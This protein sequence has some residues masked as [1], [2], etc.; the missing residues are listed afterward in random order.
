M[1]AFPSV[2][3]RLAEAMSARTVH[4]RYY[5]SEV[6]AQVLQHWA[7]GTDRV[8]AVMPTGGGKTVLFTDIVRGHLGASVAIAHRQELVAQISLTLNNFGV[9]HRLVCPPD[10]RKLIIQ[11]HLREHGVTFHD[12]NAPAAVAGVDT[13]AGII[14][15]PEYATWRQSVTL[16]VNDEAHHV[17]KDNKW[18]KAWSVFPNAKYGLG[19]TATPERPDGQGLGEHASGI[20]EAMVVGPGM[21]EL[22]DDGYLCPYQVWT[23]PFQV[24]YSAV[25]V[26]S[27]GEYVHARLVA[28]ED[29]DK[30][31]VG[32]I[33]ETYCARIPGK[34]AICFVSS[35]KKAEEVAEQF[36]QAGVPALAVDGK[37]HS[38]VREKACA[39]LAAG[40]LLVLVNCDL[41]GEGVDVPAVEAVIM[42][43]RTASFIRFTQWWGR[44]LRLA[45]TAEERAGYDELDSAGRRARIAGS[46]K[47][48]GVV[49]DH[50]GNLIE[51]NGPP[52]M[53]MLPWSLD[54]RERR[55]SGPSDAMP[56]R[57]CPNPGMEL[58]QM[59]W[60]EVR[61]AGMSDADLL[62]AGLATQRD[63]PC[64]IPYSRVHP[65][66]PACGYLPERQVRRSPEEVDGEMQLLDAETL[67][68]LAQAANKARQSPEEYRD[69]LHAQ[70][71][72]A[73]HAARN[74]KLHKEKLAVH[75]DLDR[76]MADWG[77]VWRARD[78]DDAM[79]Q[80]R[81]YLTFGVD[82]LTAQSLDRQKAEKLTA[83]IDESVKAAYL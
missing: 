76:A 2:V 40:K 68:A 64:A 38:S 73:A 25:Q 29:T 24:D 28:A 82:V 69:Q 23:V 31:L 30:K 15:K 11:R 42:G 26:G 44:M 49:I 32:K 74:V 46:A 65:A 77:G 50:G 4:L 12:P 56:Y 53:R 14:K 27:S 66:C 36:R 5:Q 75:E 63:L 51:H 61:A 39:D 17:L 45:L 18:G 10:V 58:L 81:F 43:T 6:K 1:S 33:V 72:P 13:L 54:D 79:L 21:R 35:V 78:H 83:A 20:Y 60:T 52:D 80:R 41:I 9:R 59:D 34:R 47:P 55:G 71:L 3:N 62:G 67:Q 16:V 37:S 70:R 22:I 19:V 48:F 7:E 8:L 57:V